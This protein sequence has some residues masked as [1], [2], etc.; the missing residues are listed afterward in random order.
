M[1]GNNHAVADQHQHDDHGSTK[2]YVI[3]DRGAIL[4][5]DEWW[6]S[7]SLDRGCIGFGHVGSGLGTVGVVLTHET[8]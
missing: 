3:G 1:S 7:K 8:H 4:L 5:G 6:L 2:Q